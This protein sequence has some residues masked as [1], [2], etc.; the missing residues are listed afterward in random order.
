[1]P[2]IHDAPMTAGKR[3]SGRRVETEEY[4]AFASRIIAGYRRRVGV[5]GDIGALRG[6]VDLRAELDTA[7]R[8]AGAQL[9]A[10]GYTYADLADALN[11]TKASAYDRF[12]PTQRRDWCLRCYATL[13]NGACPDCDL[14]ELVPASQLVA[15]DVMKHA[16]GDL[17]VDHIGV[18]NGF[19]R[20]MVAAPEDE[21]CE[22]WTF[23]AA[24][25]C[26]VVRRATAA[27]DWEVGVF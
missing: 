6:L 22:T 24:D 17:R 20:V 5:T 11:I 10:A 25:L 4:G 13:D 15:G 18:V 14:T 12:G 21:F 26:R 1:M 7:I 16:S 2:T 23:A 9:H 8:A 27:N 3:R 19:I